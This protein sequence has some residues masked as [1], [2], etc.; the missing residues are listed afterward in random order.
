MNVPEDLLYTK[1]HEWIRIEGKVGTI[2]I[3]DHAQSSLGDITFVELP[4]IAAKIKQLEQFATIESVK[5]ASDVF[6]P[7]SGEV[8]KINE[9]LQNTP[10]IV[11]QSPYEK[12]WFV[13]I[14]IDAQSEKANLMTAAQYKQ[15]L[16]EKE[17]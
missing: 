3:T 10:E 12:A 1:D 9:Q 6:A 7:M 13:A 17:K 4:K 11:N 16:K 14:N 15:Y 5:V 8:I 2:G